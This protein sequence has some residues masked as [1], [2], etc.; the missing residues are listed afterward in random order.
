MG[1]RVYASMS[2]GSWPEKYLFGTNLHPH[3]RETKGHALLHTLYGA[4]GS[5]D[6]S[7][8]VSFVNYTTKILH[9]NG[10]LL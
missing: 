3:S 2:K 10:F 6:V 4:T 8:G 1:K 9:K 5:S 7:S